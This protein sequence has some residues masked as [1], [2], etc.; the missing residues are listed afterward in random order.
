MKRRYI[1][2]IGAMKSGTTTLFDV[3]ATHPEIAP[4]YPKEPGFFAF[5]EIWSKGFDWFDTLFQFDPARHRYRLEGSTDYTKAPFVTGVWDRMTADPD[6]EVKLLYIMRHPLRRIE[7]H[8]R[9]V[10]THKRELGLNISAQNDHSLDA[11]LSLVNL[12]TSQYAMQLDRYA[13]ARAAGTLHF[14]T[15]EGLQN[16]PE[17]T[18]NEVFAFLGLDPAARDR[19]VPVQN[20][21]ERQA[22]V[23]PAWQRIAQS[24]A[25]ITAGKTLM[26]PG[27][28]STIRG[29]FHRPLTAEGRFRLTPTEEAM[30][31][32]T[33]APDLAR[34]REVY[35]LDTRA[36]W[37]L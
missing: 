13:E 18:L 3:L 21:A 9:H 29:W 33:L 35:R 25:L 16:D 30:L 4:A 34:L 2:I 27:M 28:R 6:V 23:H 7:S 5:E 31:T 20:S 11:G 1:L 36:F 22:R 32:E 15:M 10:Q 12:A 24:R 19:Q 37:G 26:P 8:A 17:G 14:L